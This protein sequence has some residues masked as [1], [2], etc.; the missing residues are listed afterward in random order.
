MIDEPAP[1]RRS[2]RIAYLLAST[3]LS[4]GVRVALLQAEALA[5]RGHRVTAVATQPAPDWFPLMRARFERSS[6]RDSASLA[7]ADV[8]VAA[9]WT[10]IAA[11]LDGA[12]GRVFHLSQ[13]DEGQF[14]CER[15]RWPEIEAAYRLPAGKLA[16][17]ETLRALLES[18]GLG[19]VA[20]VGQIFDLA[21][22]TPGPPR[23][24]SDPPVIL[25]VGPADV[26]RK[27]VAVALD[28]L[29]VWRRRGGSF[30]LRRVATAPP[31]PAE[32]ARGLTDEYHHRLVPDR[33]P[34][35]YRAAD[36]FIGPSRAEDAFGLSALESLACG[37]PSLLSDTPGHRELAGDAA[38]YF[39]DGDPESLAASLPALL[40]APAR[41]RA[42][43]AGPREASRCD[44]ER[45][46]Q[47]LEA[48]FLDPAGTARPEAQRLQA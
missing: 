29:A 10:T 38:W 14:L 7:E 23:P 1:P 36:V 26:D 44:P 24:A 48:V 15:D 43:E 27:G 13:G 6:F 20:N 42:R 34:F 2:L 32:L 28:G 11:A 45:A 41:A 4:G 22:H 21:A 33:M 47:R 5:R 19:P 35:A 17:S 30:R 3:E 46:A 8:R 9:S 31:T 16:V 39:A 37:V 40:E 18:R 12:R 25:L